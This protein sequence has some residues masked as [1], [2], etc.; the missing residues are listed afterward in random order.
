MIANAI[1]SEIMLEISPVDVTNGPMKLFGS[2]PFLKRY[3]VTKRDNGIS[4]RFVIMPATIETKIIFAEK[5]SK[6]R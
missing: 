3:N 4:I 6:K 1:N 5:I 2:C